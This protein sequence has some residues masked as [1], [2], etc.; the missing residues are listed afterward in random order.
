MFQPKRPGLSAAMYTEW[1]LK[2][3]LKRY[4]GDLRRSKRGEILVIEDG[5]PPHKG[6]LC[7]LARK[8]MQIKR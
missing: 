7:N 2:D 1:V 4:V 6:R 5:A 3:A 8:K